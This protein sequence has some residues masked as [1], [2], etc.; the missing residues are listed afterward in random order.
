MEVA[1]GEKNGETEERRDVW[2]EAARRARTNEQ[3]GSAERRERYSP[4]GRR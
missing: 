4:P 2:G 1:S 3:A